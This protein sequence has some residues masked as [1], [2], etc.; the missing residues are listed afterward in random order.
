MTTYFRA[1][2]TGYTFDQLLSHT[3]GDGGDGYGDV[4]GVCATVTVADLLNNT[5]MDV[6]NA[7]DEVVIFTG[8]KLETIYDGYRVR[9][10][11]LLARMSVAHFRANADQIAWDWED[12]E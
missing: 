12:Y 4:G 7:D 2:T 8:E 5:V 6:L 9:P 1:Q 3:S 10:I 11:A